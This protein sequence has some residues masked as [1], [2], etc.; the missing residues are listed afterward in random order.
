MK[1]KVIHIICV[2]VKFQV[3]SQCEAKTPTPC[4]EYIIKP[5]EQFYLRFVVTLVYS[6]ELL[7]VEL[8]T[9]QYRYCTVGPFFG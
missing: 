9:P 5:Y 1:S 4:L 3:L 6:R 2:D 8:R 7:F